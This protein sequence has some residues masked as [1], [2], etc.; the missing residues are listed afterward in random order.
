[1]LK[2]ARNSE[3]QRNQKILKKGAEGFDC[4]NLGSKRGLG[5]GKAERGVQNTEIF[6]AFVTELGNFPTLLT[7]SLHAL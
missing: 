4:E 2:L 1:M 6:N 7:N 3:K 5:W